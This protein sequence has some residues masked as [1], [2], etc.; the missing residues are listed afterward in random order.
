VKAARIPARP[1]AILAKLNRH[2]GFSIRLARLYKI[3]ATPPST[4]LKAMRRRLA[5]LLT[6]IP[7]AILAAI[8]ILWASGFT[9]E[10]VTLVK[11][12]VVANETRGYSV[13]FDRVRG[14]EYIV[15]FLEAGR[16]DLRVAV[17]YSL[18][19]SIGEVLSDASVTAGSRGY[20]SLPRG[21]LVDSIALKLASPPM[22]IPP[23][24]MESV[25]PGVLRIRYEMPGMGVNA[26]LVA[27]LRIEWFNVTVV[28]EGDFTVKAELY[29]GWDLVGVVE[30]SC[31]G[32]C[33]LEWSPEKP[34]TSIDVIAIKT[35]T[36]ARATL[37]V[38]GLLATLTLLST[39]L[40]VIMRR[41]VSESFLRFKPR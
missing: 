28:G 7:A 41:G 18:N 8:A 14:V 34:V 39:T 10:E 6:P 13:Y 2:P 31:N 12:G 36:R 33:S 22:Y 21:A 19:G 15:T 9:V 24:L 26:L 30:R 1:R 38:V 20:I 40:Y 11:G 32:V 4:R 37:L 5:L 35:D 3:L 29:N 23:S 16:A 27:R 17:L 25:E